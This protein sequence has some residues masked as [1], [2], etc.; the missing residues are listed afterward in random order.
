MGLNCS[1]SDACIVHVVIR[2]VAWHSLH[3]RIRIV[4]FWR[5]QQLQQTETYNEDLGGKTILAFRH[6][7]VI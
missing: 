6:V 1:H 7:H 4:T 3:V 5:Q 2:V